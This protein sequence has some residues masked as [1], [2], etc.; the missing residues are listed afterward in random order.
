[1]KGLIVDVDGGDDSTVLSHTSK[2]MLAVFRA[3][4][5]THVDVMASLKVLP[6]IP[7]CVDFSGMSPWLMQVASI[8]SGSRIRCILA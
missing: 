3:R 4:T 8:H 1:M 6:I 2:Q 5:T 7:T